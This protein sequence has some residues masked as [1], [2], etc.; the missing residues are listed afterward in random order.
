MGEFAK[1]LGFRDDDPF[2]KQLVL[3]LNRLQRND[4]RLL[5]LGP[6]SLWLWIVDNDRRETRGCV[7]CKNINQ[8]QLK[9]LLQILTPP[10]KEPRDGK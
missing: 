7:L 3:R 8:E 10:H 4:D 2:S 5:V 1:S 9:A 6:V